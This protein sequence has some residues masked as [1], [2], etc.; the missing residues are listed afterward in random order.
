VFFNLVKSQ[1]FEDDIKVIT[2]LVGIVA[3]GVRSMTL[4]TSHNLKL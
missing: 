4:M 2:L 3:A 1:T